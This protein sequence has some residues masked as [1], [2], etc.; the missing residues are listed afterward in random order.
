M[1]FLLK[2]KLYNLFEITLHRNIKT[3][4][5]LQHLVSTTTVYGE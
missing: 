4:Y 1:M 2:E 3:I 5:D